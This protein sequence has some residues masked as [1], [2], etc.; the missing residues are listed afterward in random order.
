MIMTSVVNVDSKAIRT[1]AVHT[2]K[3]PTDTQTLEAAPSLLM[4][5]IATEDDGRDMALLCL[6]RE[7]RGMVVNGEGICLSVAAGGFAVKRGGVVV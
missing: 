6:I 5:P 1:M 7:T 4:L 3:M 2:R